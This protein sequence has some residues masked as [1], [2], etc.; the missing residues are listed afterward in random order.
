MGQLASERQN[1]I[2]AGVVSGG[3]VI[4]RDRNLGLSG[5]DKADELRAVN[6]IDR[7][8]GTRRELSLSNPGVDS[9]LTLS[10]VVDSLADGPPFLLLII[11]TNGISGYPAGSPDF[12][13]CGRHLFP[14]QIGLL[15]DC[16]DYGI[17]RKLSVIFPCS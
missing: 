15:A 6:A 12:V 8:A 17:L 13:G 10:R 4:Y 11:G 2:V 3:R 5:V 16:A 1:L 7:E 14:F 9:G